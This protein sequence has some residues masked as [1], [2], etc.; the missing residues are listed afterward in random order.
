MA[1]VAV[2]LIR[3]AE[4]IAVTIFFAFSALFIGAIVITHMDNKASR[5]HTEKEFLDRAQRITAEI[6]RIR[7]EIHRR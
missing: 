4:I 6:D 1:E 3:A 7:D 2:A 5:P